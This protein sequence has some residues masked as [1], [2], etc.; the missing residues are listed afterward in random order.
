MTVEEKAGDQRIESDSAELA[1][2]YE[3]YINTVSA[4]EARRQNLSLLYVSLIAGGFAL[5]GANETLDPLFVAIPVVGIC[6][7]W[8]YGVRYF[9]ALSTAKFAVI[10]DLE[11]RLPFAAFTEEW[12]HFKETKRLGLTHL[13]MASPIFVGSM[14]AAYILHRIAKYAQSFN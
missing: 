12:K 11:E 1:S 14:G 4:N 13:D 10:R 3:T 9:R 6:L 2:I 7:I 8:W 5:M